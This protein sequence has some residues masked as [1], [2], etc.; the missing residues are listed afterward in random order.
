[1]ARATR[2]GSR[3]DLALLVAAVAV[4]VVALALPTSVAS[5]VQG[6][7]RGSV[8]APLVALQAWATRGRTALTEHAGTVARVDSLALAVQDAAAVR[9]ENARL[10]DMLGLGSRLQWGFVV[11]DVMHPPRGADDHSVLLSVGAAAGLRPFSPMVTSD[12]VVGMVT[13]AAEQSATAILWTHPDFRASAT[14]LDGSAFGIVSAHLGS[15]A[16]RFLLELRGVPFRTSLAP[17]AV[18]VTSGLGNVFPRGVPIGV[19][20]REIKTTEG[21]ARTYLLRPVVS[22]D[23]VSTVAVLLPPRA[24]AGVL[25]AWSTAAAAEQG[26]KQIAVAGDS[27]IADSVRQ[28]ERQ[29][30]RLDSLRRQA[31]MRG[32]TTVQVVAPTDSTTGD[33]IAQPVRMDTVATRPRPA[34]TASARPATRDTS[35]RSA[36]PAPAVPDSSSRTPVRR[37]RVDSAAKARR[38]AEENPFKLPPDTRQ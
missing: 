18:I 23:A 19:V 31:I 7:I 33:S 35:A 27:M 11:A 2:T 36:R 16:D 22:P 17:G 21:W 14:S 29:L 28:Y 37:L 8:A 34:R 12:G 24:A 4:S 32:D 30:A 25:A 26:Q 9:A 3:A 13:S 10:R 5:R 1:M 38:A 20:L 15:G 6:G